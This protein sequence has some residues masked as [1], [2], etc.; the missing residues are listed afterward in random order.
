MTTDDEH[1]WAM[2]FRNEALQYKKVG[3]SILSGYSRV[4]VNDN[5]VKLVRNG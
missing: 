1:Y 5:T 2:V 3:N 4:K